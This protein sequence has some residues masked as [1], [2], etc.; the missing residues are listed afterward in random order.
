LRGI[1]VRC[2]GAENNSAE[3]RRGSTGWIR[4]FGDSLLRY[5]SSRF[6]VYSRQ[7]A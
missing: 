2:N 7:S 3:R 5:R 1:G 6:M 4:N